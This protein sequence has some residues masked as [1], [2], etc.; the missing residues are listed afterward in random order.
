MHS[1]ITRIIPW[2]GWGVYAYSERNATA[3]YHPVITPDDPHNW[4]LPAVTHPFPTS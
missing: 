1:L 4:G 2:Y 3:V